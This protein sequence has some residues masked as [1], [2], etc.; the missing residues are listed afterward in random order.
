MTGQHDPTPFPMES[1]EPADS[2]RGCGP[3]NARR[4]ASNFDCCGGPPPTGAGP[5]ERPGYKVCDHVK[6]FYEVASRPVPVVRTEFSFSDRIGALKVRLGIGR[7]NYRVSPGLYAAGRPDSASQVLVTA[8][9]KLTFDALRHCLTGIE[10]W[11]LVVDTCGINVW[12][13]AGKGTFSTEEVVHRLEA[14]GLSQ[15]VD[16]RTLV[17]P[18]LAATG[19]SALEVHRK[20]GFSVV[21]GPV[22]AADV[23]KFFDSE[24]KADPESRRVTF[25][26]AERLV[27]IPAELSAAARPSLAILVA[28]FIL[29]GIGPGVFSL[30]EAGSRGLTAAAAYLAGVVAGG[31]L[32]PALLPWIPGRAFSVKGGLVGCAAGFIV[33]VAVPG[34]LGFWGWLA[35][36]SMTLA[37]ASYLAMNFT[38]ATPFTSPSG[39]EKEMR[40]AIPL[41]AAVSL[42]SVGA[43][44]ASAFWM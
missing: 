26:L 19:V 9:Y 13:A 2:C 28:L 6:T 33:A 36:M 40:R 38:G 20:S 10:A 35:V 4:D 15:V 1:S 16:H 24:M 8:N 44:I 22:H 31:I 42:V 39:V 23:P 37:V 32:A 14:T 41:Q 21:W 7:E 29:S 27:L 25:S 43:W 12:C 30:T 18:Q 34:R 17:L 5:W 11:I 3:A